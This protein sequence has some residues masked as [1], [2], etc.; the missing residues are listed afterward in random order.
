VT[1]PAPVKL[2]LWGANASG[3]TT[4]LAALLLAAQL[5]ENGTWR[6]DTEDADSKL[7]MRDQMA[8]LRRREFPAASQTVTEL[9][10]VL[11][12]YP[13]GSLAKLAK[14]IWVHRGRRVV[15]RLD[16]V[17][18]PGG[19]YDERSTSSGPQLQTVLDHLDA[20]HGLVYL[21]DKT[22]PLRDSYEFFGAVLNEL[23]SRFRA[24][25]RLTRNGTL[26]HSLAVC[27][28]KLD[29]PRVFELARRA[30]VVHKDPGSA[31]VPSVPEENAE[32]LF[33]SLAADGA[34][35]L[36]VRSIANNFEPSRVRYFGTSAVGFLLGRRGVFNP[37][38]YT[39]VNTVN[40]A[41]RIRG[42]VRPINVLEPLLW[43]EQS[44]RGLLPATRP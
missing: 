17:D 33:H 9:S 31:S 13:G 24:A 20:G 2:G 23:R 34:E 6:I 35:D 32:R 41:G 14:S 37:N 43:L 25:N 29:D 10:W 4:F 15:V 19:I 36:I 38:D 30:G 21:F 42:D 16:V 18:C 12:G 7:F 5:S 1:D 26:P 22:R 40:G 3:K 39:N 27:V 8:A 11:D 44:V 28:T